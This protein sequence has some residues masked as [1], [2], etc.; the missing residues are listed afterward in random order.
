MQQPN[1]Y[2]ITEVV[3]LSNQQKVN[4]QGKARE[5]V[6]R[7]AIDLGFEIYDIKFFATDKGCTYKTKI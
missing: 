6:L 5:D 1:R 7:T 3:K 2:I 4:A